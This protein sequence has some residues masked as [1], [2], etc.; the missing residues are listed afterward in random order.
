MQQTED[1]ALI[2]VLEAFGLDE[3]RGQKV[4]H[5]NAAGDV[6]PYEVFLAELKRVEHSRR[7]YKVLDDLIPRRTAAC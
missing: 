2:R 6:V 7:E 1:E 4:F 5:R 3:S